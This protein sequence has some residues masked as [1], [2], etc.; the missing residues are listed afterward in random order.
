MLAF[1]FV[2]TGNSKLKEL[3][4]IAQ[5]G[6]EEVSMRLTK[7]F[8]S[9]FIALFCRSGSLFADYTIVLKNS[10]RITVKSYRE[11]KEMVMLYGLGGEI[12]IARK[13]IQ[14]IQQAGGSEPQG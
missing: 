4:T 12:G 6:Q 11:E 10:G 8:V 14:S 2:K 5:G 3:S 7:T 9:G 1:L 13:R